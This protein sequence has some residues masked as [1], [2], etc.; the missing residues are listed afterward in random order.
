MRFNERPD[1]YAARALLVKDSKEAP[2]QG[3]IHSFESFGSV[4]GPGVRFVVFMQGCAM[5]CRYCHNPDSWKMRAGEAHDTDEVVQKALRYRLYWGDEGGVTVSGGEALLQLDFVTELFE[6]LKAEGVNTCLDTAAGPYRENPEWL[7]KFD[8]L[9]RATDLV[10]LDLK[11]MD[12]KVHRDLTGIGNEGILA[13]ARRI[14]SLGVKMWIRRVLVPGLTDR[15]DELRALGDFVRSLRNV[16]R[17]EVLPY[18]SLGIYK[19]EKL[20]LPYTLKDAEPPTEAQV[21]RAYEISG[22]PRS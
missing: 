13:C 18:H 17:F 7:A 11:E 19:W 5:R 3:F 15:E 1:R 4:D 14:D 22:L 2:M 10:M 21:A 8:R 12:S 20:G 9:M 16:T 6:K